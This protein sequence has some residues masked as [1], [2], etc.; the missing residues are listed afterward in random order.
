MTHEVNEAIA[1][2]GNA[3]KRVKVHD[4]QVVFKLPAPVKELVKEIAVARGV[5]DA[6]IHREA[7]AEYFEKRGFGSK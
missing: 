1:A 3:G 4:E 5:S 7:L 6:A 2:L